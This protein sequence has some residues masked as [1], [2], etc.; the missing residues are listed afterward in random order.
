[1]TPERRPFLTESRMTN[2]A[3]HAA[4]AESVM[5]PTFNQ[6]RRLAAAVYGTAPALFTHQYGEMAVDW[7]GHP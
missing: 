5:A 6:Y 2:A 1:M 4:A 7:G 3:P